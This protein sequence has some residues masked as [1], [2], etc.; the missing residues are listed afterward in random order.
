[1]K[2]TLLAITS[3]ITTIGATTSV[4]LAT[5][6][7]PTEIQKQLSTTANAITVAGATAIFGLMDDD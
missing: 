2:K 1:M 6:D 3:V 4:Y 5:L 7:N